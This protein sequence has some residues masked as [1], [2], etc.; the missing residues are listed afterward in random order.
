MFVVSL[1][2]ERLTLWQILGNLSLFQE[3]VHVV[4]EFLLRHAARSYKA[5]SISKAVNHVVRMRGCI[6]IAGLA[7]AAG[8]SPRHLARRFI[9]SVGMRPKLFARVV[10]FQAALGSKALH[11]GKS[12]TEVAHEFGYFDQMHT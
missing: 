11:S 2:R 7:E 4:N 6:D 3:R 9:D 12:W 1:A 8:V 5:T 10:R